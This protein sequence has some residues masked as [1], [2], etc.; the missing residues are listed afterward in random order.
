MVAKVLGFF[1]F[2]S[3]PSSFGGH[4]ST[5]S[6]TLSANATPV[7]VSRAM[8]MSEL[9]RPRSLS[10]TQ[11]PATRNVQGEPGGEG[12]VRRY[13]KSEDSSGVREIAVGSAARLD[14]K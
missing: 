14:M 13:A 10:R 3:P 8:S 4:L 12:T 7:H 6:T 1:E 11:P 2:L 9:S 5:C